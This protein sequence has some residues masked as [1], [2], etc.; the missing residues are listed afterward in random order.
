[1][2]RAFLLVD[3]LHGLKTT[4]LQ[5][6]ELFRHQAIPHQVILSKADRL[7]MSGR[8]KG[9]SETSQELGFQRL[10]EFVEQLKKQIQPRGDGPPALGEILACGSPNARKK[11][12]YGPMNGL[13]NL[14]S[15]RWAILAAT[16]AVPGQKIMAA[17]KKQSVLV[18]DVE[19]EDGGEDIEDIRRSQG[20]AEVG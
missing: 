12:R 10:D 6:L 3:A 16:G 8:G 9:I 14:D 5:I 1:M 2:R 11:K 19:E 4:D 7:F 13:L 17:S 20:V 15:I 18:G